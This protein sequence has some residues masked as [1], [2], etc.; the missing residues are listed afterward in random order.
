MTNQER[1]ELYESGQLHRAIAVELLDW[2]G[3]W[4][5][6]GV[7]GITDPLTKAQTKQAISIIVTDLAYANKVVASLA[8]SDATIAQAEVED[9]TEQM[10]K[11]VVTGIMT[12]KL[13][14]LTGIDSVE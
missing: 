7:D 3:Y 12:N 1:W 5:T 9:I 10:I 13:E 14:W 11:S 4:T 6:A 2:A 8:I